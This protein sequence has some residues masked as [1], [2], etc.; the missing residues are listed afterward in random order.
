[1]KRYSLWVKS[2]VFFL[3]VVTLL[4]VAVSGLGIL[5]AESVSMYHYDDYKDWRYS[6]SSNMAEALAH[7]VMQDYAGKYSKCPQWLLEQTGYAYAIENDI[8]WYELSEE[9]WYYTILDPSGKEVASTKK[10]LEDPLVFAF[11]DMSYAY[12]VIVSRP[13]TIQEPE[14]TVPDVTEVPSETTPTQPEEPST[15]PTVTWTVSEYNPN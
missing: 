12:P 1:M 14:T 9:D 11:G 5:A 7:R 13:G 4:G 6:R 15:A 8:S 2:L 10:E 3:A